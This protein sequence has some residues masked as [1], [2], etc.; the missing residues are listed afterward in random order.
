VPPPP[1]PPLPL[2][3]LVGNPCFFVFFFLAKGL[4]ETPE[5]IPLSDEFLAAFGKREREFD[6]ARGVELDFDHDIQSEEDDNDYDDNGDKDNKSNSKTKK[7]KRI[8]GEGD[9]DSIPTARAGK[10]PP[11]GSF[12]VKISNLAYRTT[13]DTLTKACLRFGTL[14]EVNLLLDTDMVPPQGGGGAVHN[15]GLAYVTFDTED[16]ALSCVDGLRTL[17]GRALR[18][19]MAASRGRAS[20][21][22]A[23]GGG[24]A[25]AAPAGGGSG[26]LLNIAMTR[27]ISTVCFR[28]GQ[29]GH[30][31]A[32]CTNAAKARPCPL[33]GSTD[34]EQRGC[35]GNTICF[36]CGSPGHLNRDCQY[37]RGSLPRRMVCGT[38]LQPGHH[39]M[40]CRVRSESELPPRTLD[41][42][43]CMA[44]GRVGRGFLCCR[45]LKWF[46]G[47]KGQSCFNCGMQGHSGYDCQRPGLHQCMQ[48]PDLA[49]REIERAEALSV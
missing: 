24:G 48:D 26:S 25:S 37:P 8:E 32:E 4:V 7:R 38:C 44:C 20:G 33:C 18:V 16:G 1:P 10:Q 19:S 21:T 5:I 41:G 27:D 13:E 46:F 42:A 17:D 12:K 28:C 36:N 47:L 23:G 14:G 6:K 22:G 43:V 34:H 2:Y 30:R 39:R 3:R 15:S 35:P 49:I 40:Q 45:G 31:E 11:R 9:L 29:V